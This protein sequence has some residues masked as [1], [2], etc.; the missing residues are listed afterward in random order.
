[1]RPEFPARLFSHKEVLVNRSMLKFGMSMLAVLF[2]ASMAQAQATRT[3]VSGVGDDANPCSRTAP[4]KTFAGAI[5][6]TAANGEISTLDPG[7]FGA[8]TITK[9]IT[10]SGDGTLAGI[11]SAGTSG[12]I[13]N[14]GVND[15]II[16]RNISINGAGTGTNGIRFLAGKSL[17]V[18]NV[19]ISGFTTV[20]ID[21][22]V[23]ATGV[24]V[25]IQDTNITRGSN[26]VANTSTGIKLQTTVGQV[27]ATLSNVRLEGLNNGL[28]AFTGGRATITNSVIS[29]NASNGILSSSATARINVDS[30]QVAFNSLVGVNSSVSGGII[31][32]ANSQIY[33]NNTGIS[34][35]AGALVESDGNNRVAGN[36][37]STAPNGVIPQQ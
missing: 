13:I 26:A 11:L 1:V 22:A 19:T 18:E 27:E 35:A 28:D 29:G 31:R 36:V 20:G 25:H 37:G 21:V 33:N 15:K 23:A 14:A 34:I 7:G 16:L 9:A 24:R 4:C 12:V 2:A 8:V 10:I 3:W 5:S 30:C 6:K 32:L 17:V